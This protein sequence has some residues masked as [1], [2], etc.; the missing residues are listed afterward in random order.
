MMGFCEHD[1]KHGVSAKDWES[2]D[3]MS[4]YELLYR[5][6]FRSI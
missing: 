4:D 1:I 2:L 3:Y 6:E 5:T